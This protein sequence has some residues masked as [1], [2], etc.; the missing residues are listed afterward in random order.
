[1]VLRGAEVLMTDRSET[2]Q[3]PS[4]CSVTSGG[5]EF[6]NNCTECCR[7]SRMGQYMV[8]NGL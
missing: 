8:E 1:M 3:A 4:D 2:H 7:S 5:A 6:L